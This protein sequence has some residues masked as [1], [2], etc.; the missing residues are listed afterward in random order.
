MARKGYVYVMSN[1]RRTVLYI[2]VT[3]NIV[4]RTSQHKSGYGSRFTSQYHCC[5]LIYYERFDSIEDAIAREKQLK[6]WNRSWKMRL[7]CKRNPDLRDL[8]NEIWREDE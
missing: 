7:I 4:R 3:S 1:P 8:S 5:D 6:K 2:G